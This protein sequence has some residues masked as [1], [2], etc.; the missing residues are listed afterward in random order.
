MPIDVSPLFQPLTVR[1]KTFSNR[2][3]APPMVVARGIGTPEAI[4]WYGGLARGGAGFV[5]VEATDMPRLIGGGPEGYPQVAPE[6]LRRQ[7]G[8]IHAGGALAGFRNVGASVSM[9]EEED[10]EITAIRTLSPMEFATP[11]TETK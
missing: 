5:I 2:I 7:V 3:V 8:A 1:G 9:V 10:T 11:T 6:D 4:D